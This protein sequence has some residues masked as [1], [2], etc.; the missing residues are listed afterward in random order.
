MQKIAYSIS[1][2]ALLY[3]APA[4]AQEPPKIHFKGAQVFYE[5]GNI[6]NGVEL[7]LDTLDNM[8]TQR[9]GGTF[10]LEASRGEHL[11]LYLGAGSIFWHAIPAIANQSASKVFYG[12]AI[13]TKAFAQF[14][15]G[16]PEHPG[17]V[18]KLGFFP[19]KYGYSKN[20]GEYLFRTG[21]YPDFIVTGNGYTAVN[22]S[23]A[24][25]LGT[26]WTHPI[27]EKFSH[28]LFFTSERLSYPLH[29][30]SLTY[31]AKFHTGFV[32]LGLGLQMDRLIPVTP[33]LTTPNDPKNT[34]F[35]YKGITY[36]NN[37]EYYS[38]RAKAATLDG[39]SAE[40]AQWT[41][42]GT[43]VDSLRTAWETDPASQPKLEKYSFKGIKPLALLALDFK[44]LFG[45]DLF[46][47][48][49]M[50]LY[51]EAVLMGFEN[52]PIYY[53]DRMDRLAVMVG[54]NIPTFGLL[55]NLNIEVERLTAKHIN[56]YRTAREGA[57]P[58][59]DYHYDQTKGYDPD[60]WFSDNL[61]WS[62]FLNKKIIEGFHLQTQVASDHLR[63]RRFT[64]V[65]SENSLLVDDSHWYYMVKLQASL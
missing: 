27:S 18:G 54:L 43:L 62:V 60:D 2:A 53:E 21:T 63:G 33:S 41:A 35:K 47:G 8:W 38:D 16:D 12:D 48:D 6:V 20:L 34:Y 30:F 56:G 57:L 61:K 4:T 17:L 9:F 14:N 45:G 29:D 23:S 49:E 55:D 19:V 24:S 5:F 46:R 32:K 1:L 37:P 42:I 31:L 40:A 64:R 36:A 10:D 13:L 26:Q 51:S 39:N 3:A 22:T 28:D 50:V 15:V 52:R 58:L 11:K 65:V 59:P 44:T 7:A 25:V